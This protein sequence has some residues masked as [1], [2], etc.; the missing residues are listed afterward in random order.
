MHATHTAHCKCVL[1]KLKH[2]AIQARLSLI[3][4]VELRN[5]IGSDVHKS[6][7]ILTFTPADTASC[8]ERTQDCEELVKKEVRTVFSNALIRF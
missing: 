8:N 3:G 4:G 7:A 1:G 2:C 6:S 5:V